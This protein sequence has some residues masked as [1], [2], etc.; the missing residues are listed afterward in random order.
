M[1]TKRESLPSFAVWALFDALTASD[2]KRDSLQMSKITKL[3]KIDADAIVGGLSAPGKMP[4]PAYSISAKECKTGSKLRLIPGSRCADCYALKNRYIFAS[5]EEAQARRLATIVAALANDEAREKWVAAMA[6]LLVG[7]DHFRWHDAGDI[8]SPQHFALIVDVCRATPKTR[9]WLPTGE[10]RFVKRAGVKL[11]DNLIVRVSATM[12]D[13]P[14]PKGLRH[15]SSIHH[16]RAPVKGSHVC[17]ASTQDGK[18]GPCR[19][20]WDPEVQNVSYP[21]H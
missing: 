19:A 4:G 15:T 17:P 10:L 11:P 3:R 5:T 8:Q 14:A 1:T 13:E 2:Q 18:C 20:C 16:E 9:H 6:R 21:K 12:V 7:V